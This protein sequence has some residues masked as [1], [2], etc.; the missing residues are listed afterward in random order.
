MLGS[1]RLVRALCATVL[2]LREAADYSATRRAATPGELKV[3]PCGEYA[4]PPSGAGLRLFDRRLVDLDRDL[5]LRD[6]HGGERDQDDE[7][8]EPEPL[9]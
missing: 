4:T 3:A 5:A 6:R 2:F 8:A 1:G 9:P 7:Q